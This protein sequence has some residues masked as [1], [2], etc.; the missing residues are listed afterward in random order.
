MLTKLS[1]VINFIIT[2]IREFFMFVDI[3]QITR[4]VEAG[5]ATVTLNS[6]KTGKHYTYKI[7][8]ISDNSTIYYVNLLTN[9]DNSGRYTYIGTY[10]SVSK[11][12]RITSKSKMTYNSTPVKA[13]M[14]F[15]KGLYRREIM[16]DLE[17]LHD[18]KCGRCNRKLTTP[19][20]IKYGFGP[21]CIKLV[22][23]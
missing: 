23:S 20:S 4:F 12:F 3:D 2:I 22:C 9:G 8:K 21:E 19:E 15:C 13:F 14:Y 7:K 11:L 5:N 16:K 1:D 6:M 17:V 18:N 10:N